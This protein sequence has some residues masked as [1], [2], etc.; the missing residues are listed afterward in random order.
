MEVCK[1]VSVDLEME[2]Q[3]REVQHLN[4]P[5]QVLG[6]RCQP[7]KLGMYWTH[8]PGLS[9][10][11]P[12]YLTHQSEKK[13]EENSNKLISAGL[14]FVRQCEEIRGCYPHLH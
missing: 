12:P 3:Y 6:S 14:N 13:I 8:S 11:L 1:K 5:N 4:K 2:G 10:S 9:H 7:S